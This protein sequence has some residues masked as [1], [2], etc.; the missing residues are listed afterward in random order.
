M[1]KRDA[2]VVRGYDYEE[3]GRGLYRI[4]DWIWSGGIGVEN[5]L[6]GVIA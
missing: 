6:T 1:R 4:W 3:M 2:I 5:L